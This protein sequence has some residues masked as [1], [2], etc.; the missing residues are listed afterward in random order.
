[1]IGRGHTVLARA[2]ER[3]SAR[4]ARAPCAL[5]AALQRRNWEQEGEKGGIWEEK[6]SKANPKQ[7]KYI[8]PFTKNEDLAS[9]F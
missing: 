4:T 8:T 2:L 7:A 6:S 9:K 1:L 5:A 3:L